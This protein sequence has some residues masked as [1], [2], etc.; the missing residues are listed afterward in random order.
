MPSLGVRSS[1]LQQWKDCWKVK[2]HIQLSQKAK[3]HTKTNWLLFLK[4]EKKM[5]FLFQAIIVFFSHSLKNKSKVTMLKNSS[6]LSLATMCKV[7]KSIFIKKFYP[8]IL[9][10]ENL[11][12]KNMVKSDCSNL[13]N[14]CESTIGIHQS[15]AT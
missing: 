13:I 14:K 8:R 6:L 12:Y 10:P 15:I 11:P 9:V 4:T 3:L 7:K 5:D 2:F 1:C